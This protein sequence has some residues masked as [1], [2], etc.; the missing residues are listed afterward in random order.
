MKKHLLSTVSVF[1]NENEYLKEWIEYH[2]LL[3]VDHFYMYD[4]DGGIEAMK[5]LKPYEEA[6]IVTRHSWTH[7]DGTKHDKRTQFWERDKSHIAYAHAAKNYRSKTQWLQKL[8]IDEFLLAKKDI[9]IK[10]WLRSLDTKR[11]KGYRVYRFNFGN[12]GHLVKPDGLIIENYLRREK[13]YSNYK[14]AAN[15][16][17]LSSNRYIYNSHRWGYKSFK[18]GG[19]L[20]DFEEI[21][22]QINHYYSKSYEEYRTRQNVMRSRDTSLDAFNDLNESHND[23]RDT[24]ILKYLE[25]L[26][27]KINPTESLMYS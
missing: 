21:P 26:K 23:V 15:G 13:K 14:D 20:T 7:F 19:I 27:S 1:K 12:N 22:I 18:G 8:D 6:G 4:Q 16:D 11:V 9:D 5:I 17:F 10:D 25:P 24:R 2:I 3:G